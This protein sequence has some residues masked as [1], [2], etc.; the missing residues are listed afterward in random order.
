MPYIGRNH[1]AG[2]HTSNFKVLDDISSYTATFDGSATAVV[3]T[4]D[5]T[6]RIPEHRFIQ[7]QR[8]TY[9]NGGGSNIG[10]L[11]SGTA[12]FVTFDTANTIKLATSLANANSNTNINLSSVGGG[13]SHTLNA[14]F[15]GINTQF[16]ATHNNGDAVNINNSSQLQIAI[17]NVIQKPNENS[18]YTEGFR[19]VDSRKIQFKTAPTVD[20]IFWGSILANTI[21][22]FDISDLKIDNFTGDGSTTQFTLTKDVPNNQSILVTLDGVTQHASDNSTA[23]SY[24]LVTDSIIQFTAAPG[25][26]V[27]IQVRHLGFAGAST[28]DVS[29][30]YGRTG[31]VV[32]GASD[33]ITTGDITSRDITPRNINSSGIVTASSFSGGFS[34]NIVGTSA[35]FTG[36]L[37]VGGVLTYEDV[38]NI[39]SVGIITAQKDIHVGAGVSAV[40]VGTFG[41]IKVGTGI[42]IGTAGVGTFT[43]VQAIDSFAC[44]KYPTTKISFPTNQDHLQIF[45]SNTQRM[46][47]YAGGTIFI[48]AEAQGPSGNAA[49]YLNQ[50]STSV[51]SD[52]SR[53]YDQ[54]N[55]AM[56][57]IK[58]YNATGGGEA[59]IVL[60]NDN[61]GAGVVAIYGKKRSNYI[62]DCIFRFRDSGSTSVESFRVRTTDIQVGTGVTIE[63]NGQAT[64]S[65]IVTA[66]T[67]YGDGSNLS[68]ITSTTINN[69]AD[70]RIITGSGTANTL[71]GESG[72]TYNGSSLNVAGQ[73]TVDGGNGND[74]IFELKGER[75]YLKLTD[76]DQN[77]DYQFTVNN[78]NFFIVDATTS[79]TKL[80]IGPSGITAADKFKV[81]TGTT[82]ETNGQATYTGIVTA[83]SFKLSDGSAVGGV[84]SDSDQNTVGGTNAGDSITSGSGLRNTV[85]GYDAGTAIT[86]G[87]NNTFFGTDAGKAIT[88]TTTNTAIGWDALSNQAGG[89]TNT[90]IGAKAL[91]NCQGDDN[92]AVGYGALQSLN[93]GGQNTA[94]GYGAGGQGSTNGY[95]NTAIGFEALKYAAGYTNSNYNV[96][97]GWKAFDRSTNSTVGVVAVGKEAGAGV[98]D[99][100]HSVFIGYEAAHTNTYN[101]PNC[102][103]IGG[104][105]N[106]SATNVSNEITLGD[107]NISHFRMP[108]IGVSFGRNGATIA[109][110]V[111]AT[112]FSGDGSNLT[113]ITGTT[114]NNNANNRLITGSGTANTLEGESTATYDGTKL[115]LSGGSGSSQHVNMLELKHLNT[116]S[117]SGNGDGPA[118]LLNGYYSSNEW[119]LAKIAAVNAGGQYGGGYGGGLQFW[120]HPTNGTQTASVIKGA[121]IIGNNGGADLYITDGD[122][123]VASGHGIDFSATGDGSGSNQA[124]LFDDY[125]EG[126]WTPTVQSGN[127]SFSGMTGRYTKVGRNVSLWFRINGG[128]SYSGSSALQIGG[129]P[130]T[131]N[132]SGIHPVGTSEFYKIDFARDYSDHCTPYLSG[133]NILWLRNNSGGGSG[134]YLTINLFY[135]SAAITGWIQYY[136]DS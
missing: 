34:G 2:D 33:H 60:H 94:I 58:N 87:D 89:Y 48:G 98:D 36:N 82:I 30:F 79:T 49:L 121:E 20:D 122:I 4:A 92:V 25:N 115:F 96:G 126:S 5:E 113:G 128:G 42:T 131:N 117:S 24:S 99:G 44:Q 57:H 90:A 114:I 8:V 70:N 80:T 22:T 32:L 62:S 123:K 97:V 61:G 7:G 116:A 67:F 63:T 81:G 55:H 12:Y 40:G 136:T 135:T 18:S 39:D 50:S 134:N 119:A 14:A 78:G 69:N 93:D 107:S 133:Q 132:T 17:N 45:T 120:V 35:T 75:V 6:I 41:Q 129:I 130:F 53:L 102:I 74:G 104:N 88:S 54:P 109:G 37:S 105:A 15:D 56:V 111:T 118:L 19:V 21:E 26:G 52:S 100:T 43:S 65:G 23:R 47:F 95:Y 51:F 125:E 29:G 31:N 59:G 112:S 9:S 86:S 76:T 72:L 124:E 108:G 1:I 84:T 73:M 13:T 68:N 28:G 127:A 77:S 110:V 66:S 16:K 71:N 10:G 101:L 85:F 27:E 11:T 46:R 64:F 106:P 3:S 83:S 38:T 103:V 91:F